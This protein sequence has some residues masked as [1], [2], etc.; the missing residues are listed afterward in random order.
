MRSS[1]SSVLL[2]GAGPIV[3]GQ[4][5]EFDYSGTQA[6]KALRA[7]GIRVILVNS[8][9]ATIMTDPGMAE[10]TYIEPLTPEALTAILEKERPEAL[11]PTMGGQTALNLAL[12]LEHQ[13]VLK[14][15]GVQLIGA[16]AEAI[17]RAEDREKFREV[18]RQI[19]LETPRARLAGSLDEAVAALEYVGLPAV[20]R[21]SFT[22]GGTGGGIAW[23]RQA[24]L[25]LADQALQASPAGSV[26][27]EESVVGWKEFELEVVRDCADNCIIVCSIENFDPMGV[28][29]GDSIAVA[30]AQTLTDREYQTMR[31]AAFAILRA[32]GVETGGSNVQFAVCP[33]TGR[34]LVIEMNPR[35]SR[36]SA[37][38]S[39]A[40]GFPIAKIATLLALGYRLDELA[41][42]IT[43]KKTP[44][45]FEPSIDYVVTKIP[46]FAF[47]K[48]RGTSYRLTT[49]MKSV[50][51]V[52]AIGRSFEESLQKA[53]RSLETNLEG[54]DPIQPAQSWGGHLPEHTPGHTPERISETPVPDAPPEARPALAEASRVD[55][56]DK[57]A[58]HDQ[59]VFPSPKRLLALAQAFRHGYPLEKIHALTAIDPWFLEK[60]AGLVHLEEHL[61][62]G[63]PEDAPTLRWV[64]R[65]GFSDKKIARLAGA[66]CT[67]LDVREK[68]EKLGI[69][70]VYR[71]L[72]SCAA[73]F[74]SSSC[75]MYSCFEGDGLEASLCEAHPSDKRKVMVLGSGPNRIGQGIEFDY[76]CVQ[77]CYGLEAMGLETIMINCNPETVS[78]D[79]DCPARLY[80]EPLGAEEVIDIARLEQTRGTLLGVL[81]QCGG[82]TPLK[83]IRELQEASIPILGTPPHAID[84]AEDREKFK[85]LLHRLELLQ[86]ENMI[87]SS[88]DAVWA[89]A[90]KMGFPLVIRPSYVLGGQAMAILT[91]ENAMAAYLRTFGDALDHYPLLLDRYLPEALELDVDAVCDGT[92]VY[93]AGVMEHIEEAGIHSGDSACSYPPHSLAPE[94]VAEA[95]RQTRLLALELG[96]VGLINVQYAVKDGTL[97]VLEVN[98]R[99]SRTLP[100]IS[101]I[102][103]VAVAQIAARVMVGAKLADFCLPEAPP[104]SSYVAVKEAVFPFKRFEG[105]DLTLG[106]EMRS[107]G[108]V[109]GFAPDFHTAFAKAQL[110]AG[111]HLPRDGLLF[112][113]V[114]DDDKEFFLHIAQELSILGYRLGATG[115]TQRYLAAGGVSAE[116]VPKMSEGGRHIVTRIREGGVQMVFNTMRGARAMA[117]AGAM[118]REALARDVP[119]C[120]TRAGARAMVGALRKLSTVYDLEP[121]SL[122]A[123]LGIEVPG[124]P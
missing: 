112:V 87:A 116:I 23:D 73:E 77:A 67:A 13:G 120:T 86:P 57:E 107:T 88:P 63:V 29:T 10:A 95:E 42:D 102:T 35:V 41:N 25:H 121:L 78:T 12:T 8:N 9:P 56:T 43:D 90:R 30:P 34:Q 39:K 104:P 124:S 33:R 15:L 71:R 60:I 70:R 59:L 72:D 68:R 4:A 81:L 96:V 6:C 3:I 109:M 53:I 55:P 118:R 66:G 79:F 51:E 32:I 49:S 92:Q 61:K 101:K 106:P 11:L 54:L 14:R 21:P 7:E 64:K 85:A 76:A 97:Y 46:R 2:I 45:S 108:E 83:L 44:A 115:G 69:R 98:P 38:A 113:S 31:N 111:L 94:L 52:M 99:A 50:G 1:F 93:I 18:M 62:T 47:E 114:H 75:Y 91:D 19:G 82:Q 17:E 89:H 27:V 37:L 84:L 24:F 122:Q 100:F 28:H 117:D 65:M 20:L 36:S 48:L 26:L 22:L 123:Y 103:G 74:P 105:V 119:L 5:C 110:A 80:F 58:F 16:R 40:T